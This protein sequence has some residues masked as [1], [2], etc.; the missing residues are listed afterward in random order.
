MTDLTLSP[1]APDA[2][3]RVLDAIR[4]FPHIA[5]TVGVPDLLRALD[6]DDAIVAVI[7]SGP[8][9]LRRL[10]DALEQPEPLLDLSPR[11]YPSIRAWRQV[12]P[13]DW[14]D[15]CHRDPL[16]HAAVL[17]RAAKEWDTEARVVAHLSRHSAAV[18]REQADH[19]MRQAADVLAKASKENSR[20]AAA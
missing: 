10:A 5:E 14:K 6:E 1:D 19:Y 15:T 2:V 4:E 8:H 18:C 9:Q 20:D 16:W 11:D 17:E 12:R 13:K 7:E 3:T